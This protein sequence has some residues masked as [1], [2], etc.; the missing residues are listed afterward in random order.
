MIC[1]STIIFFRLFPFL[2][3]LDTF[4]FT[5]LYISLYLPL[6][7]CLTLYSLWNLF[8]FV[9]NC[10]LQLFVNQSC[11]HH[12][13][14]LN[15]IFS[16]D[17]FTPPPSFLIRGSLKFLLYFAFLI[18]IDWCFIDLLSF[19][20]GENCGE[21]SLCCTYLRTTIYLPLSV[22]LSCR[23]KQDNCYWTF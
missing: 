12:Y 13:H 17:L 23:S 20:K 19:W 3:C 15:M 22:M 1:N 14:L 2:L 6:Y 16:P 8:W 18:R 4:L 11:L 7:L 9:L 10:F 21:N 5:Y